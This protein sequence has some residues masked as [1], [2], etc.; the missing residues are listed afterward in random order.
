MNLR[1]DLILG[2]ER[3]SASVVSLRSLLRI[4]AFAVP[5]AVL[6]LCVV[7]ALNNAS[8]GGRIR[9]IEGLLANLEPK[10]QKARELRQQRIANEAVLAELE[11]WSHARIDWHRQLPAL[12]AGVPALIQFQRLKIAQDLTLLNARSPARV[13]TLEIEGSATGESASPDVEALRAHLQDDPFFEPFTEASEVTR[14]DQDPQDRD[15]RIFR[16]FCTYAPREFL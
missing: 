13:F 6:V 7:M 4:A 15:K 16:I 10:K 3:R 14:Y 1:V 12:A 11:A 5:A 9:T 2:S 8:L